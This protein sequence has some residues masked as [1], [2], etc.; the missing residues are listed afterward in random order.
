M[1]ATAIN[2]LIVYH[3]D[4]GSTEKM[5]QAIAD[6]MRASHANISLELKQ[7]TQT[8]PD[9]L[10]AADVIAFGTPVHMGS[11]AWQMKKLIDES[12]SLWMENALQGKIGGVFVSGSGFGGGGGGVELTMAGLHA[13]FLEH[14][15]LVVGFP[16]NALGY[17]DG[18]LHWGVYA[19]TGN[20]EGMPA[21]I[22]DAQLTAARSYGAHLIEVTEK[23]LS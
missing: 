8:S 20:H 5:A 17:A 3:S 6:G 14:G 18:G 7:A 11:M 23:L 4:Y 15:M 2:A 12:A 19:R 10:L 22:S 1:S 21:G 9:D 13:N 16:K